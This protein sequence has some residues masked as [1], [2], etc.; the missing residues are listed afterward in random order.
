MRQPFA[1]MRVMSAEAASNDHSPTRWN[2][3]CSS[4]LICLGVAS[5]SA[6]R[7][8]SLSSSSDALPEHSIESGNMPAFSSAAFWASLAGAISQPKL[9]T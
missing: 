3:R 4:C 2:P 5:P 9:G 1:A 7:L 8:A 6:R